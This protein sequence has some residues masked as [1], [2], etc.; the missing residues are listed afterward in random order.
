MDQAIKAEWIRRLREEGRKQTTGHLRN[1]AG[2][3]CCLDVLCEMAVEAGVI[4]APSL[5]KDLGTYTYRYE[6]E[7]F[8][9]P[10]VEAE[11][12]PPPV[13]EWAGVPDSNPDVEFDN[14]RYEGPDPENPNEAFDVYGEPARSN[15]CLA[16]INDTWQFTFPQIAQI[17][18]SST[19]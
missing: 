12:L 14:P 1:E 15:D 18:E 5:D 3:Q 4:G 10:G 2:G 13:V 9:Q 17:I 16:E 19:L 8:D 6:R 11:C 7:D